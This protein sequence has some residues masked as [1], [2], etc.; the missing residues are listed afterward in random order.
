MFQNYNSVYPTA[1]ASNIDIGLRNYFL[2]IYKLMTTA[3]ALTGIIAW[4]VS[5][6]VGHVSGPLWWVIS[7]LPLAFVFILS[8]GIN[9]LSEGVAYVLFYAF[10]ASMGLSLSSIFSVFTGVSIAKALFIS[11]GTFAAFSVYGYTTGRDLSQ[12]GGFLFMGLIGIVIAGIVNLFFAS[13][14]ASFVISCITVLVFVGFTAFDTQ[15]LKQEYLSNGNV[16]GFSSQNRSSIY[17]ALQLYLDFI[18]IF[19]SLL[20]ITGVKRD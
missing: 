6:T 13:T 1:T 4:W 5:E 2:G 16:Y 18:N 19:I 12:L 10:A 11:A 14:L 3:L 7:L 9:R 17:G 15:Q 8:A 20:E